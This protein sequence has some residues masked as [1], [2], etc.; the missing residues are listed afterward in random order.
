MGLKVI[1]VD[2]GLMRIGWKSLVQIEAL[3]IIFLIKLY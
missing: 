3:E 1:F 2:K